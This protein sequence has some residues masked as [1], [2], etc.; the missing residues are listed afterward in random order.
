[1]IWHV[2][3]EASGRRPSQVT[4]IHLIE[5]FLDWLRTEGLTAK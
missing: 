3:I 2:K 5:P 1:M 4:R